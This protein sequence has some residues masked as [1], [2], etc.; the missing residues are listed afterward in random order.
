V[1]AVAPRQQ[2]RVSVI[3]AKFWHVIPLEMLPKVNTSA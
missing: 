3:S 1:V 2:V